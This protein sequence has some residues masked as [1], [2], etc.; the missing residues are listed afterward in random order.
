MRLALRRLSFTALFAEQMDR[1]PRQFELKP[2]DEILA[3]ATPIIRLG[4]GNLSPQSQSQSQSQPQ[5]QS[6]SGPIR[7]DL[8]HVT[9]H[10]SPR[11]ELAAHK[12]FAPRSH[13]PGIEALIKIEAPPPDLQEQTWGKSFLDHKNIPWGWFI[14]LGLILASGVIWSLNRVKKSDLQATRI[15]IDTE[16]VI[17][18]EAREEQEATYLITE[19]NSLTRK[20]FAATEVEV[21]AHLVRQPE[22]VRP[23][24]DH[25]YAEQPLVCHEILEIKPLQ[26]LTL[27]QHA[28][29]WLQTVEF[30]NHQ[31][32]SILIEILD[33]GQAK[34]D[35]ESFVCY[36]PMKWDTFV[37]ERPAGVSFD[38]RVYLKPDSFFSH[39]FADSNHW[40]CF[41]LT[42]L[43]GREI[44]F[45]YAKANEDTTREI[46]EVLKQC[47][48][49]QASV[50]V[51]VNIPEGLQSHRGVV[52]EKLL[53][54]RWAYLNPPD[55]SP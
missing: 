28:N 10:P 11:S 16:S 48:G 5:P 36:Q 14:L 15:Q 49:H 18:K 37:N 38:F 42:T 6:Q 55:S 54:P 45:G 2:V 4:G 1:E 46:L 50:I 52:I 7:L 35:W 12:S 32:R 26:P 8:P 43:D 40:N 39:E 30:T 20:F 51:R 23:L 24:M 31:T 17:R 29:F 25:Y 41:Q 3:E 19:I 47:N 9:A 53:S 34:V 33:S 27:N 13:Q 22:R 44:L 21:L